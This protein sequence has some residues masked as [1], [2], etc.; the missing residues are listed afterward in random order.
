MKP[1]VSLYRQLL[2]EG[3]KLTDYNFRMYSL[4]RVRQGFAEDASLTG[5]AANKALAFGKDQLAMLQ[6]QA[7]LSQLYPA[8][9]SVMETN[10]FETASAEQK[11]H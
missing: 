6:R 9:P 1:A 3:K 7:I 4:R 8:A 11:R 5:E 2:R 10:T